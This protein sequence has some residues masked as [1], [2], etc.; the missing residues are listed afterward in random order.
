MNKRLIPLAIV[1]A[2]VLFLLAFVLVPAMSRK[3]E[4]R[5][6]Y[7][8][9]LGKMSVDENDIIV[10]EGMTLDSSS[11]IE[12]SPP[13][14]PIFTPMPGEFTEL[15][16]DDFSDPEVGL[17]ITPVH[18]SGFTAKYYDDGFTMY[19]QE[20]MVTGYVTKELITNNMVIDVTTTYT[21]GTES[22]FY[23]LVTR[24]TDNENFYYFMISN[25]GYYSIG[26]KVDGETTTLLP[27][28]TMQTS[29]INTSRGETN[30]ILVMCDG[31]QF[32]LY[33]NDELI[34][35]V[36]DST[37]EGYGFGFAVISGNEKGTSVSFDDVTIYGFE[38]N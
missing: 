12:T 2:I 9:F 15:L 3:Q 36:E 20:P 19:I 25:T 5:S 22:N 11:P 1:G 10:P 14:D 24:Y 16:V 18:Q 7:G 31:N 4:E 37:L 35:S 27:A 32:F 29:T 34:S 13:P 8:G 17:E 6:S 33:V 26:K 30:H 28:E 23:G 21:A 38:R